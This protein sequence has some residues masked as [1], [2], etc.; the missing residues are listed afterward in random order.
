M[1]NE[2]SGGAAEAPVTVYT[3]IGTEDAARDLATTLL[4]ERLIACANVFPVW[5]MFHW[6]GAVRSESELVMLLKTTQANVE[7][8]LKRVPEIHPYEVP[9]VEV[10]PA[11]QVHPPFAK[12]R[13]TEASPLESAA[14]RSEPR[15]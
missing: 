9:C 11:Q 8:L 15:H 14:Q 12:W 2:T 5:S 1:A 7:A 13:A 3:T 6:E 4:D 10:F